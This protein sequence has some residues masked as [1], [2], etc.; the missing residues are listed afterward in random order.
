[1]GFERPH[2]LFAKDNLD[3][4]ILKCPNHDMWIGAGDSRVSMQDMLSGEVEMMMNGIHGVLAT[5]RGDTF[6][7]DELLRNVDKQYHKL[8]NFIES[9]YKEL[10]TIASF[11]K[12]S[13]WKLMG[14]VS[15]AC[16]KPW[17]RFV[18]L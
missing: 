18:R 17:S 13:A 3:I 10:T 4:D 11:S 8:I 7:A 12:A 6:L 15:E 9:F 5:E 14:D 16:F 2:S 1:M